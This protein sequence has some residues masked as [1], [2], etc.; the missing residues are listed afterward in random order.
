MGILRSGIH[1][2]VQG[3]TGPLIGRVLRKQNVVSALPHREVW[4]NRGL[5]L[6]Q[7]KFAAVSVLL[8]QLRPFLN[9][10]FA[11]DLKRGPVQGAIRY[12]FKRVVSVQEGNVVLDYTRLVL[13][14]G[15]LAVLNSPVV[16]MAGLNTAVFSWAA[17][18][19][20]EYCRDLDRVS[21]LIYN[22]SRKMPL[23]AISAAFRSDLRYE[24]ELPDDFSGNVL[25]V[26][27]GVCGW[28][29]KWVSDSMYLGEL[30]F[31]F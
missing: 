26:Y 23:M 9:H 6:H 3:R 21:F 12:N 18:V 22:V 25:Q 14:R 8:N 4:A 16:R 17:D 28:D 1:G 19:Q 24:L 27:A 7:Q 30:I 15:R 10:G 5:S 31:N 11:Y 13:A 29:N 2:P 20:Q